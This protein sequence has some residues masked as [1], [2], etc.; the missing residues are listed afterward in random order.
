LP[1]SSP[2]VARTTLLLRRIGSGDRA[3][4]EEL[5]ELVYGE[6]RGL[7]GAYMAQERAEHTLEPTALVHEAW[8]KLMGAEPFEWAGRAHFVGVAAIAMRRV[9]ID[10]ARR[11][12][13]EKRGGGAQR[14]PLDLLVATFESR[15]ADLVALG[16][17]LDRLDGLDPEL[18]RIVERRFFAGATNAEVAA[19]LGVSERTV[20]RGWSTARAWLRAELGGGERDS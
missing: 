17:A 19:D 11:R 5:L 4:G 8:M 12:T 10:H 20:E 18:A 6:L 13:A 14:E 9:L 16:E 7:A 2:A 15:G 1:G 3:A